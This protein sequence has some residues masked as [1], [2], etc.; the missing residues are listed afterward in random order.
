MSNI[1]IVNAST[2]GHH[3]FYLA[4]IAKSL[5]SHSQITILGEFTETI[6]AYLKRYDIVA[7][8]IKWVKPDG[9]SIAAYYAQS[10]SVARKENASVVFYAF[11][12]SFLEHVLSEKSH[13]DHEVTGIWF[14]PHALDYKYRWIL[15]LK[16]RTIDRKLINRQL[17]SDLVAANI[18]KIFFLDSDAPKRLARLNKNITSIALPD[19]GESNPQMDK[20]TAR[21]YF[22]LPG[23]EKIIFLHIGS[24]ERRKG[25]TDTI[26]A[27][28]LALCDPQFRERAFLLRVGMNG[29]MSQNDR[30]KLLDLVKSGNASIVEDFVPAND[31][32]EY[33]AAADVILIP[34]RKFRF[35]SGILVNALN[36]GRP[37][38]ASN[39]GMIGKAAMKIASCACFKHRSVSSYSKALIAQCQSEPN[40]SPKID[41]FKDQ[42]IFM[43]RITD[44]FEAPTKS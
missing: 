24:P 13:V 25:L 23:K 15:S 14:H 33:F 12:D 16:K 7:S 2:S 3:P 44:S 40:I 21:Q 10:L 27:F 5:V 37:V 1:L 17:R 32:I 38:L 35:S 34:Y 43:N 20:A 22:K 28:H 42:T 11:L 39:H 9:N 31:F 19:P 36:V 18:R 30:A 29:N 8:S 41:T 26:E 6:R 4:L